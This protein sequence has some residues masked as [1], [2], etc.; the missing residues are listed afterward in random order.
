MMVNCPTTNI[1]GNSR[2]KGE[3]VDVVS[4]FAS[5]S[6]PNEG[7]AQRSNQTRRKESLKEAT[8]S[9][10]DVS[11]KVSKGTSDSKAKPHK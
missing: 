8:P 5:G 4:S 3:F 2:T 7:C 9:T 1:G 11:R 6:L 10:N